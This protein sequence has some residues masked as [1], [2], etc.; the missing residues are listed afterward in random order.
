MC[1]VCYSVIFPAKKKCEK[2]INFPLF[3]RMLCEKYIVMTPPK[4]HF[5]VI[6]YLDG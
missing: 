6:K 1:P 5:P 3:E 4:F 2:V